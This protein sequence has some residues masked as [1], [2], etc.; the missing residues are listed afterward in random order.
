MLTGP[1]T[2]TR[3][4]NQFRLKLPCRFRAQLCSFGKDC[5]RRICFFA[6]T[7]EQLR[8]PSEPVVSD[9]LAS[10]APYLQGRVSP[11]SRFSL[12]P[13][14]V[15]ALIPVQGA[16]RMAMLQPQGQLL[17]PADL[18]SGVLQPQVVYMPTAGGQA[19][20]VGPAGPTQAALAGGQQWSASGG[21]GMMF[22]PA[23]QTSGSGYYIA[24]G[25]GGAVAGAAAPEVL[26]APTMQMVG[27]SCTGAQPMQL[28]TLPDGSTVQAYPLPS[29]GV[30]AGSGMAYAPIYAAGPGAGMPMQQQW[31]QHA[32][33]QQLL[34]GTAAG[35][36]AQQPGGQQP[37]PPP[38]LQL[39]PMPEAESAAGI[40]L[41]P[42]DR[43]QYILTPAGQISG[44]RVQLDPTSYAMIGP[45]AGFGPRS[46]GAAAPASGMLQQ[47]PGRPAGT[48]TAAGV[49]DLAQQMA[50]WQ[51]R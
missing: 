50:G 48:D 10:R 13:E 2:A 24:G 26:V 6:H 15:P 51:I 42:Q 46:G 22:M 30:A 38:P 49:S 36:I 43:Q 40:G 19:V 14:Q 8:V 37:P 41:G 35:M 17:T 45:A 25:A 4:V 31:A 33:Q 1:A 12:Y 32:A 44:A 9:A 7:Q 27:G 16:G 21:S 47:G 18:S 20:A 28:M 34:Q 39:V 11:E 29:G 3:V 5:N 23:A